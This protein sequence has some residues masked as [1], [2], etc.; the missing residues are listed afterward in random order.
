MEGLVRLS[1]ICLK[2][3]L[4]VA[5]QKRKGKDEGI[6]KVENGDSLLDGLSYGVSLGIRPFRD[7]LVPRYMRIQLS[8]Q[9][10][11]SL[12]LDTS[13]FSF[14]SRTRLHPAFH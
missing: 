5:A 12:C 11:I 8:Q 14:S 10:V 2:S 3:D 4:F 9:V 1:V 6:S 13:T 7:W